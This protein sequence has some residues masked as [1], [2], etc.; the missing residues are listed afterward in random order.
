MNLR[1]YLGGQ[2]LDSIPIENDLQLKHSHDLRGETILIK[3][4]T[5]QS[6][7]SILTHVAPLV[8]QL[9]IQSA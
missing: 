4:Y 6:L 5:L 3:L 2:K 1:K 9:V 7:T 8:H